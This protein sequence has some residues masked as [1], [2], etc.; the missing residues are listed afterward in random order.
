MAHKEPRRKRRGA[1]IG[2]KGFRRE[3]SLMLWGFDEIGPFVHLHHG[4]LL[5]FWGHQDE[6]GAWGTLYSTA[7]YPTSPPPLRPIT[8]HVILVRKP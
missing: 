7:P 6:Q 4:I 8:L 3:P 1:L 5:I 2:L